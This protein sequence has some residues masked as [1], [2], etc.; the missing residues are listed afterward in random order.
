MADQIFD[1]IV[2]GSGASGG[3]VAQNSLLIGTSPQSAEA[4]DFNKDGHLDLAVSIR[5]VGNIAL[6]LGDGTGQFAVSTTVSVVC[7]TCLV[8]SR[9]TREPTSHAANSGAAKPAPKKPEN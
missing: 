1:V 9:S 4:A 8:E 2:V 3:L 5:T 6:L 7:P